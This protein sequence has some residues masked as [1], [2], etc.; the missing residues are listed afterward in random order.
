[1]KIWIK[2]TNVI[3]EFIRLTGPTA[4]LRIKDCKIYVIIDHNKFTNLEE[5]LNIINQ[6]SIFTSEP[7]EIVLPSEVESILLDTDNSI[8]DTTIKLPGTWRMNTETNR[9]IEQEKLDKILEL[10]T[11]QEGWGNSSFYFLF[12][13]F[14]KQNSHPPF[15][16]EW[17]LLWLGNYIPTS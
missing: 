10:F 15:P 7:A 8:T 3:D 4:D 17:E 2:T 14:P 16:G 11:I 5:L 9:I 1:M 13:E 12:L 6:Q